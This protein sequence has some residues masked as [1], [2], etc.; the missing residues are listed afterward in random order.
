MML[1][2]TLEG[3][4]MPTHWRMVQTLVCLSSLHCGFLLV[5][6]E[7]RPVPQ[8][9]EHWLHSL[10]WVMHFLSS[11]WFHTVRRRMSR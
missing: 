2:F 11:T 9:R 6:L 7:E 4:V 8:L 5:I 1:S 3:I 10:V